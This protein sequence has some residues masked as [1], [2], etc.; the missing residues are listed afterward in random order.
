MNLFDLNP[1][2]RKSVK[3]V[4]LYPNIT[5][6]KDLEKDSYIQVVKN[7]IEILNTI[8]DDLWFY[9]LVPKPIKS[10]EF[11]N[12]TQIT[13]NLPTYP[14]S[15]RS[16]FDVFA[17]QKV[18]SHSLDFDVV[19]CHLP[20]HAHALKNV[21]YNVTH[22][23]P[24]F[25]GYCHWF[26]LKEV[27]TGPKDTFTQNLLGVLE[28]EKCYLNTQHQKDMVMNQATDHFN[29]AQLERLDEILTVQ[30]LGVNESDIL[31]GNVPYEKTIVFNHRPEAYKHFN[32][33]MKLMDKLAETRNDF[34]VWVPLLEKENR[35]YVFVTKP[36]KKEYYDLLK[37]CAV[38]FS[39]KQ[40]YGGWSVA[41]TDGLM[42]GVPYL[43]YDDL[44]YRELWDGADFF[45]SDEGALSLLNKYLDDKEY[46][47]KKSN[48]ARKHLR[49]NLVYRDK[50][51]EMNDY[52]N[53]LI[54]NTHTVGETE[55][56]NSIVK[57]IQNKKAVSKIDIMHFLGWGRGV[58]WTP[59]RR[60][61]SK[62]PNIVEQLTETPTYC[63]EDTPS[64]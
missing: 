53:T 17:M 41:T 8:R 52:M 13:I 16:H 22:F 49:E 40:K 26:D 38:G 57:L 14:Q 32:E 10:L 21:M 9:A 60:A 20:E 62:H 15:M 31:D 39:P 29:E 18:I 43:M 58:P 59:Y 7:Q 56:F 46:R 44:Y 63:Y 54:E 50:M 12:T 35:E 47:D 51:I 64:V 33:F 2:K 19:M 37:K 23:R 45:T 42:N 27:V 1:V 6:Q 55:T 4:L 61:L 28:Y 30:H 34:K 5:F 36:R 3:R 48:E 25:M 11:E 24:L